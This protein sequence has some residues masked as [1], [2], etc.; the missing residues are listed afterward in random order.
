L[1]ENF[2]V[3]FNFIFIGIQIND[4]KIPNGVYSDLEKNLIT[5][6]VLFSFNDVD[7]RWI[8]LDNWTY[9]ITFDVPDDFLMHSFLILTFDGVDTIA[10]VTLNDQFLGQTQNMFTR[11]SYNVRQILKPE[12]QLKLEFTSPV[13]FAKSINQFKIPPECPPKVYNGECHMNLLRKMQAS[14]AWDW[15]LAAPSMGIWKNVYL[16]GYDSIKFRDITYDLKDV[17]NDQW[18]LDVTVFAETGKRKSQF[19][20]IIEYEIK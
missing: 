11:Y 9:F 13:T 19:N 16:D 10:N 15:G 18:M 1:R 3:N 14:F 8:G 20:G 2:R 5:E 7:L 6:S 17:N 4:I 12:N